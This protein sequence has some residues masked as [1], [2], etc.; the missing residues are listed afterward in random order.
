MVILFQYLGFHL[1]LFSA[2]VYLRL[3]LHLQTLL[4]L[5]PPPLSTPPVV[6]LSPPWLLPPLFGYAP[7]V[8]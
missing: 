2:S 4:S 3:Y 5:Y 6:F 1:S 7:L 8:L